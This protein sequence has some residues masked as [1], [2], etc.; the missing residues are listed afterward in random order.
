MK[1]MAVDSNSILNRAFYGIRLLSTKEG[2]Y[3]NGIYGFLNIV[4]K[5]LEEEKP[6]AVAF[7]FDLKA[8]TFRHD[9][10]EGYKGQRKGMPD[11]LAEQLP[12]LKELLGLMGYKILECP[13]Y[14]ADDIL[15]TLA[16]CCAQNGESCVIAT[17]DRDSL[18][19]VN[20]KTKVLL[21]TTKAG[22]PTYNLMD[23][24]AVREK[25]AGVGP[26]GL[27][28]VKALMG[29][30]SDNIPGVAGIG[31]K[32][33]L[34]LIGKYGTLEQIY[35]NLDTIEVTS[36]VREKLRN[37]KEMAFISRQLGRIHCEV[38]LDCTPSRYQKEGGDPA[39]LYRLLAK[40]ELFTV[41]KRLGLTPP[42]TG[43][44]PKEATAAPASAKPFVVTEN[45]MAALEALIQS[46]E[47][48]CLLCGFVSG[49]IAGFAAAGDHKVCSF[50]E[51]CQEAFH[52]LLQSDVPKKVEGA[53]TIYKYAIQK[54]VEANHIVFDSELAGYLLSPN[55]TEYTVERLA[56]E[57][58]VAAVELCPEPPFAA[59]VFLSEISHFIPLCDTLSRQIEKSGQ[60]PLL[61][62]IELPLSQVL[63][64]MEAEG[65]AVDIPGLR[66]FGEELDRMITALQ[67][68]IYELC[69]ESFNI[70]SPKQLGVILFEKLGLPAKKKTKSGYSTDAEV[71]ES[72]APHHPAVAKILEYRRYAKLK[73]TYVDGLTAAAGPDGRIR[74]SFRQ[75]ETRTGRISS[76]EPNLQN[77]PI[78]TE[79]GSRMREFFHAAPGKMLID[80]DYSQI[81]LRVLASIAGDENMIA[82]FQSGEDIHANTAAQVFD[83]PALF[84][85]PDM[86]RKA[87]AV[88]FGI[89]YGIG[90]FSLSKDIGVS[91]SEADRYIK[92]YLATYNGVKAYMEN[93]IASGKRDG[94]VTTLFGRRRFLPELQSSNHQLRSFGE[95]VAMNTPIQGTAAD[96]I[97][98]AMVRVWRRLREEGLSAKLILQ[99]HDELIVEAPAAEVA[100]ASNILR[101]EMEKA[102]QLAVPLEV[103]LGTGHSWQEAHG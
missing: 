11:E 38:P 28:D 89:V 54:G 79:I 13:G 91:V 66:A 42:A 40:L 97:K 1:L 100:A 60:T 39:G 19:L 72:L 95:R 101:A 99:V 56:G 59:P 53:K 30:A 36:S 84:V 63:G 71:L 68:D 7:A 86:R 10:F 15:G 25:Y 78:R 94:Y 61:C 47:P 44:A 5:L 23:E 57:Y 92:N 75:T 45:D 81:E 21:A 70:N 9:M 32:T 62:D 22:Q 3:T 74:S 17:G 65:F 82:A 51:G 83:M 90:A 102:A 43:G 87:K 35:D 98:I 48:V 33:A 88:N 16:T 50:Q 55:S 76:T 41:I 96:I 80:A 67:G 34:T 93:T 52:R 58:G 37:G 46:G 14:E 103:D 8:P 6:D 26:E 18:Q 77:I 64:S 31:E 69:G 2:I 49:E 20:D 85:T 12:Y 24:A 4:Q 27:V 29:D 73:S